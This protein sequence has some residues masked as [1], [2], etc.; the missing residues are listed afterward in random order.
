MIMFLTK[1]TQSNND[2]KKRHFLPLFL[3]SMFFLGVLCG[4]KKDDFSQS[5]RLENQNTITQKFFNNNRSVDL[6]QAALV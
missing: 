1:F 5:I 4:C 3:I 2:A 6:K